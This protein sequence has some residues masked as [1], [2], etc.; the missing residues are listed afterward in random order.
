MCTTGGSSLDGLIR[1]GAEYHFLHQQW[2]NFRE[3]SR[4][5]VR[6]AFNDGSCVM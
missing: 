2:K 3:I 4:V 6:G 5:G 1:G